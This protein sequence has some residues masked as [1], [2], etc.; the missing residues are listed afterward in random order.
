MLK[1]I[2]T[3]FM[4]RKKFWLLPLLIAISIIGLA[5]V[6]GPSSPLAPFVYTLF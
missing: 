4:L 3:Y 6:I 5:T 2:F 1:H